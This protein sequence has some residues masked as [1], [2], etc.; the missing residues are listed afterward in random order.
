MAYGLC[1]ACVGMGPCV[2]ALL[3]VARLLDIQSEVFIQQ[4]PHSNMLISS[5]PI[6]FSS[7]SL[8]PTTH[9]AGPKQV[10]RGAVFFGGVGLV[11]ESVCDIIG[12][13]ITEYKDKRAKQRF[14]QPTT[15]PAWGGNKGLGR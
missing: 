8:Q 6:P 7:P 4:L 15:P 13:S 5:I 14:G 10:V 3:L 9:T 11:A 2:Q 12:M 1:S